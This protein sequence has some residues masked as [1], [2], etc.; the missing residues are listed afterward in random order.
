MFCPNCG[1]KLDEGV[2]FCTNC[3]ARQKTAEQ[4]EKADVTPEQQESPQN[5]QA[6]GSDKPVLEDASKSTTEVLNDENTQGSEPSQESDNVQGNDSASPETPI[7]ETEEPAMQSY[8]PQGLETSQNPENSVIEKE[9]AKPESEVEVAETQSDQSAQGQGETEPSQPTTQ[10]NGT[11]DAVQDTTEQATSDAPTNSEPAA[12]VQAAPATPTQAAPAPPSQVAP[13]TP[14]QAA[15]NAQQDSSYAHRDTVESEEASK[16]K[17]GLLL[18]IGIPIILIA[19]VAAG[20]YFYNRN[21]GQIGTDPRILAMENFVEEVNQRLDNSPFKVVGLLNECLVD[22]KVTVNVTYDDSSDYYT[23]IGNASFV[24]SSDSKEREYALQ[25][26][27]SYID[28]YWD[29]NQQYEF[30]AF[31]NKERI[32]V[33][34]RMLDDKYYGILYSTFRDDFQTFAERFGLDSFTVEA[35]TAMVEAINEYM[36]NPSGNREI[37]EEDLLVFN[38]FRELCESS[39][40]SVDLANYGRTGSG[41]RYDL[42]ITKEA[43]LVL[44]EDIYE[45]LETNQDIRDAFNQASSYM[46]G[47]NY[48]MI[49]RTFR[50]LI[51]SFDKSYNESSS[52]IF[53]AIFDD[54]R[55]IILELDVDMTVEVYGTSERVHLNGQYDFGASGTDLWTYTFTFEDVSIVAS[56]DYNEMSNGFIENLFTITADGEAVRFGSQWQPST[57]EFT[58]FV[59]DDSG[60]YD[61]KAFG[62]FLIHNDNKGFNFTL[63]SFYDGYNTYEE[64]TIEIIGDS[65][66]SIKKIEFIGIDQWDEMLFMKIAALFSDEYTSDDYFETENSNDINESSEATTTPLPIPE[67]SITVESP[68]PIDDLATPYAYEEVDEE[69]RYDD[70]PIAT[71][72]EDTSPVDDDQIS[73][74]AEDEVAASQDA[75]QAAM[76]AN[77]SETLES[78]EE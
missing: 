11:P 7:K 75:N 54:S 20:I 9:E 64:L 43:I 26:A 46:Y 44:L 68:A 71:E 31:I 56:W 33:G 30:E 29:V 25:A 37:T 15:P 77:D 73:E 69:D 48:N 13:A 55:L 51:T 10:A 39:T 63:G 53:S 78:S 16:P 58:L 27:I 45:I 57:G 47:M 49:L 5:L 21:N 35:A 38:N 1:T 67:I 28:S 41:T 8:E 2:R 65:T 22:G 17:K 14:T 76:S 66:A 19:L 36:N 52:L 34:S 24:L 70:E 18:K 4:D 62:N 50:E 12:P 61:S 6:S 72:D 23:E 60:W 59:E 3:G 32:A 40:G 42:S 74:Y